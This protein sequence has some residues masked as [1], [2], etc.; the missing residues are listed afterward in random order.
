M[1]PLTVGARENIEFGQRSYVP[2]SGNRVI[3]LLNDT[4][5]ATMLTAVS[6]ME[7]AALETGSIA[8]KGY[9]VDR[10]IVTRAVIDAVAISSSFHLAS[11]IRF[12]LMAGAFVANHKGHLKTADELDRF[13][14]DAAAIAR[15][16]DE[17]A[18]E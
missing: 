8:A 1:R 2:G 3:A 12:E 4:I 11:V 15:R 7:P 5:K 14:K 16:L 13:C 6:R 17:E 10:R 9:N 18:C